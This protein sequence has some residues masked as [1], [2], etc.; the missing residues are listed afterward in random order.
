M[1]Q[2]VM[3][4]PAALDEPW[5]QQIL[6]RVQSLNLPIIELPRNR[7]TGL[8]GEDE[9]KT[10]DIAKRTLAVVTAPPSH[11]KLSPIPPSAD[12]Q[13]HIAEGCPAHCQYCYLA[14][15]LSG[16]PVIRTFANLPQ[17]LNNLTSYERPEKVTTYE[18]SCYTDPLGIEH[19]TGSLAECIRYFGTRSDAHLRWVSKFDEVDSL[20]D[21]PH[22]GHTHCRM[23]VNAAP[24]SG[25]F[26]G[27][28]ASV[29]SRLG[30]LRKLADSGYPVGLVIAP[31]MPVDDWQVH[32]RGLF[33]SISEA[34]D[35]NCNLTFELISHRFTPG[36]KEVLQTWY[37]HSKLDMDEE[38]RSIKRN[39]FGG[40]KYVY[41]AD[42]MNMMKRFFQ[43][44]IQQRFP[45]AKILYWT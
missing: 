44:E 27:G 20:L 26:E 42:T 19:L 17:I 36:S 6:E 24:V 28:T 14:G 25:R 5:G 10:Y 12:W 45:N 29:A 43:G 35:F 22:N 18:V 37:P 7:V 23:S 30:A 39:K 31:I 41:D 32:Y 38:K 11:F 4:T 2:Q 40:T 16:P 3:F 13:F 15:S 34:L 8:R 33:D 21:L 9:R 1:P